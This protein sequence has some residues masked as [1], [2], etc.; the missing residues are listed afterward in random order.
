MLIIRQ[1]GGNMNVFCR[2]I[3]F[4]KDIEISKKFY[5]EVIGQK[6]CEDYSVIVVFENNFVIHEANALLKTIYKRS[7]ITNKLKGK[8]NIDIYFETD[9]IEESYQTVLAHNARIIH[10]IEKQAWGQ[11]VFRFYDP[12]NHI[13]EIGEAFQIESLKK[14]RPETNDKQ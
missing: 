14:G 1:T 6:V 9:D 5:Q 8:K 10:G 2:T 13:L 3:V 11:K 7:P 12:D 4:V